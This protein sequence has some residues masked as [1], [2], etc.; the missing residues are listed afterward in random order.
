MGDPAKKRKLY[1]NPRKQWDSQLLER[2][3]KLVEFY[4]LKNK[5]ELRRTETWLRQK[6]K[7]ARDLLGLPLEIRK[8]REAEL[9]NGLK[10]IGLVKE[11]STIDDVLGLKIEEVL[12][13]RLQTYVYRKGFAN[14]TKQARQFV[15]HGHIAIAGKKISA[16][17]YMVPLSEVETIGWYRKPIKIE[18]QAQKDVKDLKKEFEEIAEPQE[19]EQE[20]AEKEGEM[21]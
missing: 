6:K 19:E 3:R 18:A 11:G 10:K 17:S 8:Q 2:E 4:G 14:T 9:M 16:P 5:R 21:E 12:E 20:N 15:V 13:R 7:L 1:K